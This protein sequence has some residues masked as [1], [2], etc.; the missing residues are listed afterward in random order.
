[1]SFLKDSENSKALLYYAG[2]ITAA[3]GAGY[4]IHRK[5]TTPRAR[6][7]P[8]TPDTLPAGAYDA[9]IVGAG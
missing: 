8:Y 6:K 9:I 1:M 5:L 4:L 2:G 3:V 7:G